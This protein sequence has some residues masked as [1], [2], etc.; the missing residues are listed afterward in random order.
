[1]GMEF[2]IY[3]SIFLDSVIKGFYFLFNYA[4]KG[5]ATAS[6]RSW[7]LFSELLRN[8]KPRRAKTML[9]TKDITRLARDDLS[10]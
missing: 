9:E 1:M 7:P 6:G 10:C 5:R 4:A 3:T 2:Q 8:W